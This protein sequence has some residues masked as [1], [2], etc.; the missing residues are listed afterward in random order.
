M[1]GTTLITK[2]NWYCIISEHE[3]EPQ[4]PRTTQNNTV[5]TK[6]DEKEV[7]QYGIIIDA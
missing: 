4:F 2:N 3:T 7:R 6:Q 1:A 5:A